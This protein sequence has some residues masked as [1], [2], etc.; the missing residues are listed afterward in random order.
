MIALALHP[1]QKRVFNKAGSH[2]LAMYVCQK[3]PQDVHSYRCGTTVALIGGR[4][5]L[6]P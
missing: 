2:F 6:S 4:D 5:A 3:M 1:Y